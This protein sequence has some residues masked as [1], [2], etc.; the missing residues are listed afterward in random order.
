VLR[1]W[2]IVPATWLLDQ[3]P[4]DELISLIERRVLDKLAATQQEGKP[5]SK[6]AVLRHF[7]VFREDQDLEERLADARARRKSGVG[8]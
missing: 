2:R 4:P 7:G 6:Q 5:G 1:E 8:G 3:P